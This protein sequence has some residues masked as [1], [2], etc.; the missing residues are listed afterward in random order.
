MLKPTVKI[1]QELNKQQVTLQCDGAD[2]Y[3]TVSTLKSNRK[4]LAS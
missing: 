1:Q 2:W 4:Q 3:L